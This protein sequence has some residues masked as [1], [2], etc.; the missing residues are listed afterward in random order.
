MVH[1]DRERDRDNEGLVGEIV[2]IDGEYYKCLGVECWPKGGPIRRGE[3][4][5]LLVREPVTDA[6]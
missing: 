3:E 4:I 6:A 2:V 1:C 5:G